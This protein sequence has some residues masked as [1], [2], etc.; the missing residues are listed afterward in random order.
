[1]EQQLINRQTLNKCWGSN[2]LKLQP[3]VLSELSFSFFPFFTKKK[4]KGKKGFKLELHIQICLNINTHT[5]TQAPMARLQ[6]SICTDKRVDSG[7]VFICCLDE[8]EKKGNF[9]TSQLQPKWLWLLFEHVQKIT[10][11]NKIKKKAQG[12][13]N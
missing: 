12:K 6:V 3:G 11:K 9:F 13:N 8:M 7:L 10:Y 4:K 5:Y 2:S 1:M